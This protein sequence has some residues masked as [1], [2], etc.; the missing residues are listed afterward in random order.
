[1]VLILTTK[2]FLGVFGLTRINLRFI[3]KM[4]MFS[5]L[6]IKGNIIIF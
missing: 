5:R 3:L 2:A 4:G 6:L 1:M